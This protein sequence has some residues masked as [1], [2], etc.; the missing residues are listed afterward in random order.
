MRKIVLFTVSVLICTAVADSNLASVDNIG[1]ISPAFSRVF[2]IGTADMSWTISPEYSTLI[3]SGEGTTQ[4]IITIPSDTDSGLD[5][6]LD[7]DG[8][9][10][11]PDDYPVDTSAGW[12]DLFD[13]GEDDCIG[14]HIS[15]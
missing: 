13:W 15:W 4:L 12:D 7:G 2:Y 1:S 6:D 10:T 9:G 5:S 14:W 8:Y 11:G 3:L